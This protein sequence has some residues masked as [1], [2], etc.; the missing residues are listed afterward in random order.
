[1]ITGT[2][3]NATTVTL[4]TIIGL[5][6]GKRIKADIKDSVLK[7]LALSVIVLGI[8][9]AFE[10]H[11]FLAVLISLVLGTIFGEMIDIEKK[12]DNLGAYIQKKT[13][14]DSGT[15]VLG[16]VTSSILFCVGSMTIIGAI[17]DGLNNDPSVLYVKS[18]LDGVSSIILS[19]TL[20]IGVL[21]SVII[22]L[23]YQGGLSLLAS[24]ALFLMENEIYV[25]GI[26]VAGGIIIIGIGLNMLNLTKIKTANML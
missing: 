19:S 1:M 6:F 26:S 13:K 21:F 20:G 17:K 9:M 22:I 8:K 2:L 24:G 7:A 11:D 3:V 5:F 15:F 18:M 14:T 10:K 23:V 16:F 25:N 4:G 12:L